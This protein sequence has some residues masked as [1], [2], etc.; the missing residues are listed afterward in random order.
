MSFIGTSTPLPLL[1]QAMLLCGL[2]HVHK[3]TAVDIMSFADSGFPRENTRHTKTGELNANNQLN[4]SAATNYVLTMS[5]I[6]SRRASSRLVSPLEA[7]SCSARSFA[8]A[9]TASKPCLTGAWTFI[10]PLSDMACSCRVSVSTVG[11]LSE[12]TMIYA[13]VGSSVWWIVLVPK[14]LY[15]SPGYDSSAVG[16]QVTPHIRGGKVSLVQ[17]LLLRHVSGGSFHRETLFANKRQRWVRYYVHRPIVR[18]S[19]RYSEAKT[20]LFARFAGGC[21]LFCSCS[22]EPTD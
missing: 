2:F 9:T 20:G 13:R 6:P 8:V 17:A 3:S 12:S 15:G 16:D 1:P 14:G 11:G 5:S 7:A 19:Q 18:Q 4:F 10:Q 22:E 21:A